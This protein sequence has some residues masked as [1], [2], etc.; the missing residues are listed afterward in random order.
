MR[1]VRVRGKIWCGMRM[2]CMLISWRCMFTSTVTWDDNARCGC[3]RGVLGKDGEDGMTCGIG[4][5]VRRRGGV[6][7]AVVDGVCS[8]GGVCGI[9]MWRSGV[10]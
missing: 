2:S 7:R 8:D 6:W 3:K 1:C 10:G 4:G 5:I 9:S